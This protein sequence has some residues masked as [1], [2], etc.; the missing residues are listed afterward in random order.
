MRIA[1]IT[2]IATAFALPASTVAQSVIERFDHLPA[3]TID[4]GRPLDLEHFRV[5]IPGEGR[6]AAIRVATEDDDLA[7]GMALG[8]PDKHSLATMILYFNRPWQRVDIT[9]VA[10]ASDRAVQSVA[11]LYGTAEHPY[12]MTLWHS[13]TGH[14]ARMSLSPPNGTPFTS[15]LLHL[16]RGAY[17]DNVE[18]R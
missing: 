14:R 18:L 7:S 6:A 1:V 3:Q 2:V 15:L 10:P 17:V 8:I 11:M 16:Q 12:K 9:F 4:E 13:P 5:E